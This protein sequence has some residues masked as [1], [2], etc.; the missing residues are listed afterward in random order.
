MKIPVL[1]RIGE[2][3]YINPEKIATFTDQDGCIWLYITGAGMVRVDEPAYVVAVRDAIL[4][5]IDNTITTTKD[6]IEPA[7][8]TQTAE[9]TEAIDN[10]DRKSAWAKPTQKHRKFNEKCADCV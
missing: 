1:M 7:E 3:R 6:D 10:K 8:D 2:N 4:T 5:V 9:L